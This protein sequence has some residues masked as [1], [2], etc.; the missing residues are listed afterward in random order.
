MCVQ[1]EIVEK[2]R[3]KCSKEKTKCLFSQAN[4]Q[5]WRH[6]WHPGC[7]SH[8]RES[9]PFSS[10]TLFFRFRMQTAFQINLLPFS[11]SLIRRYTEVNLHTHT[12]KKKKKKKIVRLFV[13]YGRCNKPVR[14]RLIAHF[15]TPFWMTHFKFYHISDFCAY[16]FSIKNIRIEHCTVLTQVL[17]MHVEGNRRA[18]LH[19]YNF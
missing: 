18:F 16:G 2:E 11:V 1:V 10:L 12:H 6:Q 19:I 3:N 9:T 8:L 13:K 7:F 4:M 15:M 17:T 5:T 14:K